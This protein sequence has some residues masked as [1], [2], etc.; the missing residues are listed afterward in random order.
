VAQD[1]RHAAQELAINRVTGIGERE[2]GDP[3]H[4]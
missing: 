3:A 1:I 4:G 2:A